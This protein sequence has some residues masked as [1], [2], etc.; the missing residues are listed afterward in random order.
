MEI[1]VVS[2][3]LFLAVGVILLL[4]SKHS[5][6]K[7]YE[8]SQKLGV[9]FSTAYR[10]NT[11]SHAKDL[12]KVLEKAQE[13]GI[14]IPE[15]E[16][17]KLISFAEK[18][19]SVLPIGTAYFIAQRNDLKCSI[20]EFIDV[21]AF[22]N[23]VDFVSVWVILKESSVKAGNIILMAQLESGKDIS[24]LAATMQRAKSYEID[25]MK[26]LNCGLDV[27]E[28]KKVLDVVERTQIIGLL[29]KK[30]E[31]TK[32]KPNTLHV[33][34]SQLIDLY[35]DKSDVEKF[36]NVMSNAKNAGVP[37][38]QDVLRVYKYPDLDIEKIVNALLNSEKAGLGIPQN[39]LIQHY[40]AGKDV[41][42]LV[43][44]LIRAK[45]AGIEVK[46]SELLEH[47]RNSDE[48]YQIIEALI[49]SKKMNLGITL[50]E[51][52]SL[53]LAN[54][55]P[56]KYTKARKSLNINKD[57]GVSIDDLDNHFLN[58]GDG[59]RVLGLMELAKS[60]GLK[61]PFGLAAHIIKTE[62]KP[63]DFV[64]RSLNQRVIEL[65]RKIVVV[66]K[67]GIGIIPK[68]HVTV[69][70]KIEQ[71]SK[72]TRED[73]LAERTNEALISEIERCEGYGDVL[74]NL[75]KIAK[76][77]LKKL[78]GQTEMPLNS[79]KD[80]FSMEEEVKQFNAK[81]R[82]LNNNSFYEI[83]DVNIPDIEIADARTAKIEEVLSK[84][85]A[86][87]MKTKAEAEIIEAEAS[88]QKAM[89]EGFTK[90]TLS[91]L[92]EY[93]KSNIYKTEEKNH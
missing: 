82:E 88:I 70:E 53:C 31:V 71:Y 89:A 5:P 84:A 10:I 69:R 45:I 33:T 3:L 43:S 20:A 78:L 51:L 39:E 17:K 79:Q 80:R 61:L 15:L 12:E 58:G 40:I 37:I 92:N 72:G 22:V 64:N 66:S 7:V 77:V 48:P 65:S 2:V 30:D 57:F 73:V 26:L 87:R 76:N 93:H 42:K 55:N 35:A 38:S 34:G 54:V 11:G 63:E 85:E 18:G 28:M 81:Q 50:M 32:T 44:H 91:N 19:G 14:V 60:Q 21:S 13:E 9:P 27:S 47:F 41:E 24:G 6:K 1:V 59:L 46:L 4:Y 49:V 52:K 67:D 16:L 8:N 25:P 56:E 23:P 62:Q 83:L 29:E 75:E 90:G 86:E 68:I 74:K 36:I